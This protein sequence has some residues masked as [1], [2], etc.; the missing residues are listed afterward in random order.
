MSPE[1]CEFADWESLG[2]IDARSGRGYDYLAQRGKA[3]NEAGIAVDTSAYRM[4]WER[5]IAHFCQTDRG[6]E[7]GIGG[8]VYGS[9]CPVELER[10]FLIGYEIG[11]A[12]HQARVTRDGEASAIEV[13][14]ARLT[15]TTGMSDRDV[16]DLEDD[17]ARRRVE[18]RQLERRL[19]QLEGQAMA[20]G[21]RP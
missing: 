19:G 17:L 11:R 3:C 12:I 10:D 4:G 13:I 5:G 14:E 7:F 8:K 20:L 15:N 21:Y 16:R 6:F 2:E 9:I 1:E 18:I